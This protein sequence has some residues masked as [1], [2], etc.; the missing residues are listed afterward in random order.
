MQTCVASGCHGRY[1]TAANLN[2]EDAMWHTLIYTPGLVAIK[3]SENSVLVW[4]LEGKLLI[5][6]PRTPLKANQISGVKKWIDEGA[7]Y[8]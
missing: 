1:Q 2:L 5:M 8:N 3:N 7:L 4:H 6:P